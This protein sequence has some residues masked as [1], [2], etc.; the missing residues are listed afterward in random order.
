MSMQEV[1]I[2][3]KVQGAE[4]LTQRE[5]IDLLDTMLQIGQADAV[6]T[7]ANEDFDEDARIEADYAANLSW[8]FG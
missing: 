6:E 7:V 8:R 2:T 4:E 1:T 5:L 3:L